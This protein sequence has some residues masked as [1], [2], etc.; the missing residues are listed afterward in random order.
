[1][2]KTMILG[3][4]LAMMLAATTPAC[5]SDTSMEAPPAAP[6]DWHAF[7]LPRHGDVAAPGPTAKEKAAGDAY[8][9]ALAAP[10]MP[11]LA[12]TLDT[13]SHFTFPGL[14]DARGKDGVLKGH[15]A[16]FGAFDGRTF[17]AARVW[18][19]DSTVAIEWTMSGTQA[20]D[21]MG[22]PASQKKVT[23]KG[24]S[25]IWTKDEGSITDVHVMF[26]VAVVK[27]QLGAGPKELAALQPATMA[28]G[29]PLI[30]E[31]AHSTE[32]TANVAEVHTW[33]DS[34]EHNDDVAY[35]AAMTD[36]VTVDEPERAVTSRGKD[37]RKA[38]FKAM[39]KAIGELDTRV[40]NAWGVGHFAVVEYS[41]NG[42]QVGPLGWI[43]AKAD[44]VVRLHVVDIVELVGG[45]IAHVTRYESPGE[46]LVTG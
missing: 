32:E 17:A 33:L 13:D 8:L 39:H 21:W 38:Y 28:S 15:D 4:S 45:K 36:D 14:P 30:T 11:A 22:V 41:V 27:T 5:T 24:V 42:E 20:R 6:V 29:A 12:A 40:D 18:R 35:L 43:P 31:Q 9:G 7:D 16:L 2:R 1:M 34:L 25:L 3:A 37:D 19:T 46:V 44:R 26:D 10:G 23:F